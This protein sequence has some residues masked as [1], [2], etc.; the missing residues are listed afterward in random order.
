MFIANTSRYND[1]GLLSTLS[2]RGQQR[3]RATESLT[4]AKSRVCR[5][6]HLAAEAPPIRFLLRGQHSQS[7][8]APSEKDMSRIKA[9][10][11][12]YQLFGISFS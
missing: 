12:L 2:L 1:A 9:V 3:L 10:P 7:Q 4:G 11:A 8:F 6:P 5:K